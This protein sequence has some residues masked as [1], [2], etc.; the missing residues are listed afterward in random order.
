MKTVFF[1]VPDGFGE[2]N[3]LCSSFINE[4]QLLKSEKGFRVVVFSN[5]ANP[6]KTLIDYLK[7][8]GIEY[9]RLLPA[10]SILKGKK[11]MV[12]RYFFQFV[13][14]RI[15]ADIVDKM[16]TYR[17][18]EQCGF[19]KHE[20]KK[21]LAHIKQKKYVRYIYPKHDHWPAWSSWFF[22]GSKTLFW[23]LTRISWS[24]LLCA[25]SR[26]DRF[27]RDYRPDLILFGN[28]QDGRLA[29]D[30]FYAKKYSVKT[31]GIVGSWD[32]TTLC[33]PCFKNLS[34][35][36]AS[37]PFMK[38]E[39]TRFHKIPEDR[40]KMSSPVQFDNYRFS[41]TR[42]EIRKKLGIPKDASVIFFPAYD[43]RLGPG[44]PSIAEHIADRIGK[45]LYVAENAWLVVRSY[46]HDNEFEERFGHIRHMPRTVLMKA[47]PVNNLDPY[48]CADDFNDLRD[49]LSIA[50]ICICGAGS[51]TIDASFFDLPVINTFFDGTLELP[52]PLS[53]RGRYN[54]DHYNNLLSLQG[55]RV[56]RSF[57]EL[58]LWIDKYLKDPGLDREGRRRI[59]VEF[60]G[61]DLGM[62]SKIIA[63]H[64][65]QIL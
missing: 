16:I 57:V 5:N 44:E 24:A 55:V 34:V 43:R 36:L 35:Y 4:L 47:Q 13:L 23:L 42:K 12:D 26:V 11:G 37:N 14:N 21:V 25:N 51:I 39:L 15:R 59:R 48:R 64:I 10:P 53:V 30:A 27:F 41:Y 20:H 9:E 6:T 22:P 38:V 8:F 58:D 7:S 3:Y 28:I 46:P 61:E 1:L 63:E 49:V 62:G 2:R 65:R 18:N 33:G 52:E 32:Q 60:G 54:V 56:V 45:G 50:S 29:S 19:K 31:I 40:I 17:F